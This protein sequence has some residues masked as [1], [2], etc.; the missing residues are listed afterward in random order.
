VKLATR[1]AV[2]WYAVGFGHGARGGLISQRK[3]RPRHRGMLAH[4]KAGVRAGSFAMKA[5]VGAY[6]VQFEIDQR[7]L[8]YA[9][10][11]LH[12]TK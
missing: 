2:R 11:W 3:G 12:K 10:N 5:F 9:R 4:W 8:L 7:S 1:A 6:A